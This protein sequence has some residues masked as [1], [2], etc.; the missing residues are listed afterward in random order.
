MGRLSRQNNSRNRESHIVGKQ[1]GL[2]ARVQ[3]LLL[4]LSFYEKVSGPQVVEEQPERVLF[5]GAGRMVNLF[6]KQQLV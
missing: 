1:V 5:W 2:L 6:C 3:G 4:P